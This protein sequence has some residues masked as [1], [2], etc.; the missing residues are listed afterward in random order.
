MMPDRWANTQKFYHKLGMNATFKTYP[1]CGHTPKPA[2]NDLVEQIE[3]V[4][5]I[6]KDCTRKI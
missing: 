3:I 2:F 1:G 6:E 5:H 4:L